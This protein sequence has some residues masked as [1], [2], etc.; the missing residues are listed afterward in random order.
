[1]WQPYLNVIA[2]Q[3]RQAVHVLDRFHIMKKMNEAIDEVRRGEARQLEEDGYEPVLKHS[4]WCLLKR[5]ENLTEKQTVKLAE[6][7]KYN[8][9]E[10]AELP[11]A[12][13]LSAVLG[14]HQSRLGGKV[15]R[16]VVYA[17]LAEPDRADEED[18]SQP[19]GTSGLDPQLVPCSRHRFG[20][21]RRGAEQQSAN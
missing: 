17:D 9:Q 1:M 7:L 15:P 21:H 8:L 4:R 5:R 19:A 2:E 14:I 13:G 18:R 11:V 10:R 16:P 12:G 6:L 20:R 3:L